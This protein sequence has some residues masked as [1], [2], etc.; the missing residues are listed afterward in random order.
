MS[1]SLSV[2]P[3]GHGGVGEGSVEDHPL[4]VEA[5]KESSLVVG[6]IVVEDRREE[7]ENDGR[8]KIEGSKDGS[9]K[10]YQG[11]IIDQK[12]D[13][14]G[15]E[16]DLN[17]EIDEEEDDNLVVIKYEWLDESTQDRC[18]HLSL[19]YMMQEAIENYFVRLGW[20]MSITLTI[21]KSD[22]MLYEVIASLISKLI[23]VAGIKSALSVN[24]DNV[25][26]CISLSVD[27]EEIMCYG[28][29]VL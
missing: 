29:R 12:G 19:L 11:Y 28:K 25:T 9:S 16:E 13:E 18:D 4:V 23:E 8:P 1:V 7:M 6:M 21:I 24:T 17:L 22:C 10:R 26:G 2:L 5:S 3:L 20:K 15:R 27:G 14:E